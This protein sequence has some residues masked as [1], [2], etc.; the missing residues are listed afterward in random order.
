MF[1]A[2][3][4]RQRNYR[5]KKGSILDENIDRQIIAIHRAIAEKIWQQPVLAMQV[6]DKLEERYEL[7]KIRYGAYLH[8]LSLLENLQA[9]RVNK[10]TFIFGLC[11]DS[12]TMRK[13]RRVTPFVGILTEQERQAALDADAAGNLDSLGHYFV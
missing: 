8:W 1:S 3:P 10:E 4:K 12:P 2:R 6:R 13:W 11:E 7:G 9:E 5:V